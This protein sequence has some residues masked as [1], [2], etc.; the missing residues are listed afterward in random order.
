M[1]IKLLSGVI[2]S[3][4]YISLCNVLNE[5]ILFFMPMNSLLYQCLG[6]NMLK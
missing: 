4:N 1:Y 5:S 6:N 2:T 3:A